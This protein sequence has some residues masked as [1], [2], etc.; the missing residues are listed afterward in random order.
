MNYIEELNIT[1]GKAI[2]YSG[3]REGQKP[4][5]ITPSYEEIKEDLLIL[6]KHWKYLRLY[7]CDQ[8]AEIVLEVIQKEKLDFKIMLGAYIV[9]ACPTPS[10]LWMSCTSTL[11]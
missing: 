5:G 10:L 7:D 2:C 9:A 3:F 4:G 6:H 11:R 8:H 1:P